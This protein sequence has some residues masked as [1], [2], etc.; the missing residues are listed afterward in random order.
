MLTHIHIQN[1]V[2]VKSL[3]IDFENGL[4]VLT[5]ETG[6]GKSIWVDA[7]Q[8]ALGGRADSRVIFDG[9]ETCAITLC[10][11]L[12]KKPQALAWLTAHDIPYSDECIIRRTLHRE[13]PSRS[14]LNGT[15]MPQHLMRDFSNH[16]INIHS[17]HQHQALQTKQY[18]AQLLDRYAQCNAL[19]AQVKN[20][21]KIYKTTEQQLDELKAIAKN[22]E[23]DLTLWRYQ[24]EELQSLD[25]QDNEYESL[26][27]NYQKLH[28]SKEMMMS[29]S[30]A[31]QLLFSDTNDTITAQINR[32]KQ[33]LTA[34]SAHNN[35]I[36]ETCS[37]LDNAIMLIDEAHDTLTKS[38][39]QDEYTLHDLPTIE[40]RMARIQD[41]ARKHQTK[42]EHLH[43]TQQTLENNIDRLVRADE[44]LQA[45]SQQLLTHKKA[46]TML[47]NKLTQE[48]TQSAQ[49]FSKAITQWMHQL[50]M[51]NSRLSLKIETDPE[52][53]T[54]TGQN[55][56][57]WQAVLNKGQNLQPI[58]QVASGGELSRISLI[59]EILTIQSTTQ[60]TLVFDEVDVGIGGETAET[61]GKL[62]RQLSNDT[63]ILCVTHLP[64]VASFGHTHF[65]AVKKVVGNHTQ[66]F[67]SK[68]D[69]NSRISELARMLSGS[70]ITENS[71]S[72]AKELLLMTNDQEV[73]Q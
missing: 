58:A 12:S 65:K 3:T 28:H 14:T 34:F 50:G 19:L 26:F 43:E 71:L 54:E 24:L 38:Q 57:E 31:Q 68:L 47:A 36:K 66:T 16:L 29:V 37:L 40:A 23:A 63:Q 42:P 32:A 6:A 62:L 18:Q 55:T 67:I 72:H 33:S 73:I 17:Q 35:S 30:Q 70:Q 46:Y 5:G 48:R 56:I 10:F 52:K 51:P 49:K 15:P 22:K 39:Q 44:E 11:D 1:F 60:P 13:K 53:I 2:I 21:Y 25:L 4:Q 7:L 61:I 59:T 20:A 64:Q 8:I 27:S 9:E 41:L 69:I 45:L